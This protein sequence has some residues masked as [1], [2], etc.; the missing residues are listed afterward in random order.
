MDS[1]D[2]KKKTILVAE[3]SDQIRD[4]IVLILSNMGYEVTGAHD[5]QDGI[6]TFRRI[7]P[8]LVISDTQMGNVDGDVFALMVKAERPETKFI[9]MSGSGEKPSHVADK[10][11]AKPVTPQTLTEMVK[12][13]IG[14]P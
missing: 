13:L 7:H 5:G 11:M 6:E 12:G 4:V 3:D 14:E 9:L 1:T 2:T 8:D 10:F